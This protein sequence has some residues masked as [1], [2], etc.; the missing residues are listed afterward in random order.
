MD[1]TDTFTNVGLSKVVARA[2][3]ELGLGNDSTVN[4][5]L[6]KIAE[7]AATHLDNQESDIYRAVCLDLV[8]GVADVPC[9]YRTFVSA[10]VDGIEYIYVNDDWF[11]ANNCDCDV[12]PDMRYFGTVRRNYNKLDFGSDLNTQAYLIYQG[13]NVDSEGNL[14]I[15]PEAVEVLAYSTVASYYR[16]RQ[17]LVMAR[18]YQSMYIAAKKNLRGV[19]AIRRSKEDRPSIQA[20]MAGRSTASQWRDAFKALAISGNPFWNYRGTGIG[21]GGIWV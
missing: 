5:V 20:M 10:C 12:P 18:E 2:K 13:L 17:N 11:R 15:E 14:V 8:C 19:I 16:R 9:G 7:E 4:F 1:F 3:I 21:L 6:E